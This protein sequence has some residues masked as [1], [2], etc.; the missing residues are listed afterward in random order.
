MSVVKW[1]IYNP[2][3]EETTRFDMNP[4][5]GGS[6]S[7]NKNMTYN[8]RSGPN[9][10]IIAFEG[11]PAPLE[12]EVSGVLLQESQYNFFKNIWD[13]QHQVRLTDDLGRVF[14]IYVTSVQFRRIR[15]ANHPWAHEYQMSYVELDVS[16]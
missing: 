11:E 14:W 13:L 7:Y 16:E 12:Y 3:T 4:A 10:G 8:D 6:P 5:E 15:R 1:E 9:S 2:V